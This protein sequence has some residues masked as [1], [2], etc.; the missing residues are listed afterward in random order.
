MKTA[1]HYRNVLMALLLVPMLAIANN[2]KDWKGKHTKEKK[3]HKEFTVNSNATVEIK[4]SY[5][6]IDVVTW[7]E[8]RVVI[9]V[10][11]TTN[12]NN[13]E[14]VM[15]KLDDIDIEFSGSSNHVHAKTKFEKRKSWW[16]WGKNNVSMKINY[17]IKM[18]ES[19]NV[20]LDNSYGSINL[21]KLEGRAV[22]DCDYGKITTKELMADN[23]DINFDYT[24][25]SYF[26]YIKSGTISADY[27]GYTVGKTK[28]LVIDAD[29]TKSKIELAEDVEYNCDYG[30][31]TIDK[32][33]NITGEGDNLSLQIG[34]VYK[35][36][37]ISADYGSCK[38]KNMTSN[39]G[40]ITIKSDYMKITIGYSA[41]YNFDFDLNLTYGS[42]RGGDNLEFSKKIEKSNSKLYTGYNGTKGSGNNINITSDYGSVTFNKN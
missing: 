12:G 26:E 28:K 20:D 6:D 7:D 31:L 33:N 35:D 11:I 38:I 1:L 21:D 41:G 36:V 14:K 32:A 40:D 15:K 13:E 4:N 17:V 23:N 18:P 22:I 29:Y 2:G 30:S 16:S 24:N 9:D 27:S 25:N 37:S 39:A 5:G 3:V 8:N 42:L 34:D 19:N 10:T